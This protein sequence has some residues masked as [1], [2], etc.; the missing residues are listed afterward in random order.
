MKNLEVSEIF[1]D[2]A[3]ILQIKGDNPFRIRAYERAAANI[4]GLSEDLER[5]IKEDSLTEIPGIGADLSDKIKE[6]NRT[7]RLRYFEDLKKTIPPG[8][9]EILKIPSIGPNTSATPCFFTI[10]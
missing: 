1:R 9:L 3:K 8:L 6:F 4:E 7:G 2:I 5:F 10:S